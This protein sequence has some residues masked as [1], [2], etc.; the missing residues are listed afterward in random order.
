VIWRGQRRREK[1][2]E[3]AMADGS[4]GRGGEGELDS[5]DWKLP[6]KRE[7]ARRLRTSR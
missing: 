4:F 2:D 3:D 1:P 6:S 7:S 5:G